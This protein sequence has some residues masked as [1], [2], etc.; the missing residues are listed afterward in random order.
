MNTKI[1]RYIH[2]KWQSE[3][4][5]SPKGA[6]YKEHE[7]LVSTRIKYMDVPRRRE[8]QI[9]RLRLNRAMLNENLFKM[10]RHADGKCEECDVPDTTRHLLLGCC[11]KNISQAIQ[12][13]CQM[14]GVD[15]TISNIFRYQSIQQVVLD[16]IAEIWGG[17]V[18]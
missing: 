7:P 10:K 13:K 6:F 12:N 3:Y 14:L 5:D 1:Q 17:K 15:C 16:K 11:R 9:T 2:K 18:V 8:V 4:T